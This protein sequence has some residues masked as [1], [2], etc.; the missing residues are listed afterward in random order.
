VHR[1][2]FHGVRGPH[3]AFSNFAPYPI[4]LKGK[5]WPT[6]EHYFQA[7]KFTGTEQEEAIRQAKSPFAAKKMGRS[8]T[9][10][11]RRDWDH[12]KKS[13]MHDAVLAKFTQHP[14][15]RWLLL[16]AGE[17]E[18]VE[19]APRDAY[20][21]DGGDGRGRNALGHILEQVREELRE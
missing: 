5:T 1:V 13:V 12:V 11:L 10:P 6:N 15:L 7:Q 18:I 4:R 3:S 17:A 2:E 20:W 21:G 14:E 9:L 19:H 8:D 16:D